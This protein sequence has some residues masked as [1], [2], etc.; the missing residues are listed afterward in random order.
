MRRWISILAYNRGITLFCE[1]DLVAKKDFDDSFSCMVLELP[2]PQ[3][4]VLERLP[5]K[6]CCGE[7]GPSYR[8]VRSKTTKAPF[9]SL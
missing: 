1:V 2:D 5:G 8:F 4:D 9:V 3:F 7:K 6:S